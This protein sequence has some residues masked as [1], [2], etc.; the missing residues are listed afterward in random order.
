MASAWGSA[1]GT[2]WLASWGD[3]GT[4]PATRERGDGASSSSYSD[5]AKRKAKSAE[6][7]KTYLK[8]SKPLVYLKHLAREVDDPAPE[9]VARKITKAVIADAVSQTPFWAQWTNATAADALPNEI[10]VPPGS[11]I[12]PHDIALAIAGYLRGLAEQ[13][14]I[15]DDE[16]E[17]EM[18]LLTA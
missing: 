1:W 9:L 10:F 6:R 18:L 12:S 11:G 13:Q 14:A 7:L 16:D 4:T 17:I 2:S 5:R 3:P 15:A 8:A